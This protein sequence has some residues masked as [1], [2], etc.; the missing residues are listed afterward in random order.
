MIQKFFGIF[1]KN[2]ARKMINTTFKTDLFVLLQQADDEMLWLVY[3]SLL[4]L[5][6]G[7]TDTPIPSQTFQKTVFL[8]KLKKVQ[9][10][11]PFSQIQDSVAWQKQQRDEWE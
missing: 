9:E 8:E 4:K 5:I 3:C 6:K 1:G 7:T 11:K 10:R 2:K